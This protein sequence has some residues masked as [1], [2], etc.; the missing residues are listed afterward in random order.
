MCFGKCAKCIGYHLLILA[1][2]CIV[3]NILLYFPNGETTYAANNLLSR[4]VWFFLGIAGAGVL[5]FLPAGVFIGLEE[6]DCCGCCGHERCGKSCAMLSSV[7]AAIIGVAGAGYCL[8]IAALALVEGPYCRTSN[9]WEY[10]FAAGNATY[11]R[12]HETWSQ[13]L[14]PKNVVVWNVT[15][16]AILLGLSAIQVI[17]CIIQIINGFFGGICGCCCEE[18]QQSYVC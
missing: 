16:F 8:I 18:K 11:L 7:L 6:E 15:L 3:A 4:Y 14:E 2:L 5:M 10:P 13:C 17:L 1:I 9:G 12:D